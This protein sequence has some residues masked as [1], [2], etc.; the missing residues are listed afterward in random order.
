ME[1]IWE[2][3]CSLSF[4]FCTL[5]HF[6]ALLIFS[7]APKSQPQP[8]HWRP[9]DIS[10]TPQGQ[11]VWNYHSHSTSSLL[12]LVKLSSF[13]MFLVQ[14]ESQ[15]QCV[16]LTQHKA[17][18]TSECEIWHLLPKQTMSIFAINSSNGEQCSQVSDSSPQPCIKVVLVRLQPFEQHAVPAKHRKTTNI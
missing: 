6:N 7:T 1:K 4:L 5:T 2:N 18:V 14:H 16:H 3:S 9:W 15:S 8:I 11:K 13:F 17:K 10:H 12:P